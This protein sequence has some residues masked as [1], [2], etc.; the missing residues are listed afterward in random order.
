MNSLK[1]TVVIVLL[2]GVS[3]GVF[4]LVNSPMLD[5]TSNEEDT[6]EVSIEEGQTLA[7]L[8]EDPADDPPPTPSDGFP[9]MPKQ[10]P[11]SKPP[12]MEDLPGEFPP[13]LGGN[14]NGLPPKLPELPLGPGES[15]GNPLPPANWQGESS[16]LEQLN[17][18]KVGEP[19][20]TQPQT[21]GMRAGEQFAETGELAGVPPRN[22]TNQLPP[23]N[24]PPAKSGINLLE[25]EP[26]L[27]DLKGQMSFNDPQ[28]QPTQPLNP[29]TP[30]S[31]SMS[32]DDAF[33]EASKLVSEEKFEPALRLLSQYYHQ[34]LAP[35]SRLELEP[36][37]IHLAI[38]SFFRPMPLWTTVSISSDAVTRF[39]PLQ[40]N[41]KSRRGW[42]T[43][44]I[45]EYCPSRD[46]MR[47]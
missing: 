19:P 45:D 44:S 12:K 47:D 30:R 27:D 46:L 22:G 38:A 28:G 6:P 5:E 33:V 14:E 20:G 8:G 34:D 11:D 29:K 13:L 39:L 41:G 40:R 4:Q 15:L 42:Y 24:E 18:G 26:R 32:L 17:Q 25:S 9:Q 35:Q 3:Y 10:V 2:L 7:G 37:W 1:N 16:P 21:G 43:T 36:G 31:L 23:L